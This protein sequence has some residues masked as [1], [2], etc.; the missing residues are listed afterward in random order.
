[1]PS[2]R[3]TLGAYKEWCLLR[4]KKCIAME[5]HNVI[6]VGW[7]MLVGDGKRI[8]SEVVVEMWCLSAL[9]EAS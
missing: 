2:C 5:S 3:L 7:R 6:H 1:M 4:N 8:Q 9:S